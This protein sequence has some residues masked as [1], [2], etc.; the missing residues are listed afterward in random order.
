DTISRPCRAFSP[1]VVCVRRPRMGPAPRHYIGRMGLFTPGREQL[2]VDWR[3]PA[4]AAFYRATSTDRQSV[5]LRRHLINRG[6]AVVGLED[7]VLDQ[8]IIDDPD[9]DVVLQ[10]EGALLAAVS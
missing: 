9:H 3:A 4:A 7:D 10:G 2:L 8:S 1:T 6:R 5:R